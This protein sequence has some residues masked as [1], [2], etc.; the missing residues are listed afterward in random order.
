MALGTQGQLDLL[1][2]S[3]GPFVG[4]LGPRSHRGLLGVPLLHSLT[5]C[6]MAQ[7]PGPSHNRRAQFGKVH[8]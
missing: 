3:M 1:F 4:S 2:G 7:F 5:M 6:S 8:A